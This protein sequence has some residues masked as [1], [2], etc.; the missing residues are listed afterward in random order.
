MSCSH[1]HR[2][3]ENSHGKELARSHSD[4]QNVDGAGLQSFRRRKQIGDFFQP[5]FVP[6]E[7][8]SDAEVDMMRDSLGQQTSIA[9][10]TG[11]DA[12]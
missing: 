6:A 12:R 3:D 10:T 5:A 11:N 2:F 9:W 1:K 4:Q 8:A 7:L